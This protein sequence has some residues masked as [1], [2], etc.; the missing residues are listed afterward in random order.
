SVGTGS[1]RRSTS[2]CF[3]TST[4][5]ARTAPPA[6]AM[7]ARLRSARCSS[8]SAI[9]TRA[10]CSAN[11]LAIAPPMPSAPPPVTTAT[12]PSSNLLQFLMAGTSV[13]CCVVIS[14]PPDGPC[15]VP[16]GGR[17]SHP[18]VARW[19][20]RRTPRQPSED[21]AMSDLPKIISVDDHVVEPPDLWTSRLPKKYSD[22]WP[23][24]E[25]DRG[26]FNMIG[27]VFSFEKGIPD[28]QWGDWWLYDDLIYPFPRLSAAIGFPD[29]DNTPVT[30]DEIRPGCWKL[31]ER[32]KDMDDNH[33]EASICF[34]NVLP[35]FCGQ[36]FLERK[37][38]ELALLCVQAY[39][40]WMIDE[41]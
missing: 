22:R 36:T 2:S 12:L 11:N 8:I 7:A 20:V 27:G 23:R 13:G 39:N 5:W 9:S 28:G 32:L 17:P 21:V 25:R 35:R 37:D 26:R 6:P 18:G 24:V 1:A 41:W 19:C 10:P 15:T 14:S 34:P 38:K 31:P 29:L 16:A 40:D 4:T 3:T 33:V 30:F